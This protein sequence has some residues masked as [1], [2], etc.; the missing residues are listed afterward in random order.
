MLE[1]EVV[2]GCIYKVLE[3][4]IEDWRIIMMNRRRNIFINTIHTYVFSEIADLIRCISIKG[5]CMHVRFNIW[6]TIK[7]KCTFGSLYFYLF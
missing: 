6:Q 2:I 1:W 3:D 7:E 4:D 5:A